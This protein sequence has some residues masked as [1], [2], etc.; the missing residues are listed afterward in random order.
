MASRKLAPV[1]RS[2]ERLFAAGL[3]GVHVDE[4]RLRVRS[5]LIDAVLPL[6]A[7]AEAERKFPREAL[8]HLGTSG[9]IRE[10]WPAGDP[11][12]EG[13]AV[14]LC[15]E[16]G[17]TG[18]G[19]L[20]IGLLLQVQAV[21]SILVKFGRNELLSNYAAAVLDGELIGCL[22]AT[23]SHGGSD[24][25]SVTTTAA[26]EG[27]GWRI[28]GSKWFVSPGGAAD[29]VIALC[30]LEG[31]GDLALAVVPRSG[32]QARQLD[33]MGVRSLATARLSIDAAIP[34]EAMIAASGS[35]L[36]AITWGLTHE[37]LGVAAFMLGTAVLA[38]ELSTT[39]LQR[40]STFGSRLFDHQALR[41]RLAAMWSEVRLAQRGMHA[42]AATFSTPDAASARECAGIKATVSLLA[43]R[44]VTECMHLFGGSGYLDTESPLARL[45]GDCHLGRLGAGT[46]EM[47]WELVAGGL[48]P[49]DD[50]YD[51]FVDVTA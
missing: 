1:G 32:F 49:A 10:R 43:E 41:L 14:I 40:R 30:R 6:L 4:Y 36:R 13:R 45:L 31:S 24:L 8:R 46:D 20:G 21:L 9:L 29:F 51:R 19:G 47:M 22:A 18:L 3:A 15:E 28:R 7:Q 27:D 17:R 34:E 26:R 2:S 50:V 35:G 42:V 37:R 33:T 11:G 39:H 16:L 38:L 44:V 48:L 25:S 12:D 23:E 5:V